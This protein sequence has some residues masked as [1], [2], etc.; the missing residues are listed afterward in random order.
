ME[1]LAGRKSITVR[2]YRGGPRRLLWFAEFHLWMRSDSF[3]SVPTKQG[4]R[5]C[6]RFHVSEAGRR[7][8]L[9]GGNVL[10]RRS[11]AL[12]EEI[13]LHLLNDYFLILAA[14]GIEAVLVQQHL[15]ELRPLLPGLLGD[16]LVDFLA[17][18]G[19]EGRLL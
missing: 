15:A 16:I 17:K 2:G 5:R 8:F 10:H 18:V 9:G 14:G 6:P 13:F 1:W 4:K 7:L 19:V 11:C 12:P 3:S